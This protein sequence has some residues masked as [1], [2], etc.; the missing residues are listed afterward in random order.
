LDDLETFLKAFSTL[1][2]VSHFSEKLIGL[3]LKRNE[4]IFRTVLRRA[5]RVSADAFNSG[6]GNSGSSD[7][8]RGDSGRGDSGSGDSGSGDS[9]GSIDSVDSVDSSDRGDSGDNSD[10]GDSGSD[11]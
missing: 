6:S 2:A 4:N 8:G 1:K 5:C 3:R 11:W 7:S 10:N 9:G